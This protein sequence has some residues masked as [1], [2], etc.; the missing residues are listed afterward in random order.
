[1]GADYFIVV[2]L[3]VQT[4]WKHTSGILRTRNSS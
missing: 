3:D 2:D 4:V 1:M